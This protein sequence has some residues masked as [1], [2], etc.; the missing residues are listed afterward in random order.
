MERHRV[1][2]G[3]LFDYCHSISRVLRHERGVWLIQAADSASINLSGKRRPDSCEPMGINQR[4]NTSDTQEESTMTRHSAR[5]AS[6][7]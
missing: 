4:L 3:S 5:T 1:G 2:L 7:S 6:E